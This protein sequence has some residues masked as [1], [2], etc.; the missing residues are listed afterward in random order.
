MEP[1]ERVE[2]AVLAGE[3]GPGFAAAQGCT[4]YAS[5]QNRHLGV[6]CQHGLVPEQGSTRS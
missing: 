5:L 4:E 2:L 6:C 1:L 3:Q